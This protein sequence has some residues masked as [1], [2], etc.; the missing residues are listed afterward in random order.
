MSHPTDSDKF[1]DNVKKLGGDAV[2]AAHSIVNAI[3]DAWGPSASGKG[4]LHPSDLK[5]ANATLNDL[6]PNCDLF[7]AASSGIG[8]S[9]FNAAS[10]AS[11]SPT[12]AATLGLAAGMIVGSI[13]SP[14]QQ[15]AAIGHG[16]KEA[17][18]V[19]SMAVVNDSD[20][21]SLES[22]YGQISGL[23]PEGQF[24]QARVGAVLEAA[25]GKLAAARASSEFNPADSAGYAQQF[26][27]RDAYVA[28]KQQ[29]L[30]DQVGDKKE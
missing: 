15:S 21:G 17:G 7:S 22:A 6:F 13:P 9:T 28:F 11:M 24:A 19:G 18:R 29:Q 26:G 20:V 10:L 4:G 25:R 3:S 30:K 5:A 2:D 14:E 27:S 23:T 1:T 8:K 16:D 12:D